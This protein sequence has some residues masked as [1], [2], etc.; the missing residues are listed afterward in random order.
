ME[1]SVEKKEWGNGAFTYALKEGLSGKADGYGAKK[2]SFISTYE[3][4]NWVRD[5]V[6]ELT[7]QQ[8]RAYHYAVPPSL[9]PFPI[10]LL[11]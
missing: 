10:Y 2:D 8:Q 3:L 5:R 4:G 6:K 1:F 7:D 11:R 9:E